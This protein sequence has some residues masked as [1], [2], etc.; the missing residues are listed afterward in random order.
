MKISLREEG[1]RGGGMDW[2]DLDQSRNQWRGT[3]N[4]IKN[5]RVLQN[6][7]NFLTN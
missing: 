5:F 3:F 7:R 4:E 2:I 6:A 1:M